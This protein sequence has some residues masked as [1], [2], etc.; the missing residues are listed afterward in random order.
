M[1]EMENF[2]IQNCGKWL[3]T[4]WQLKLCSL[5]PGP[6]MI[7]QPWWPCPQSRQLLFV[8]APSLE[9]PALR[10]HK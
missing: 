4:L 7:M 3:N 1:R 2:I 10:S 8:P 5:D 9:G 6:L